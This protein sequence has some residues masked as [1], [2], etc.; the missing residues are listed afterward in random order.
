MVISQGTTLWNIDTANV[1]TGKKFVF[2]EPMVSTI[3]GVFSFKN[4]RRLCVGT[5]MVS[6]TVPLLKL[7]TEK[8]WENWKCL[9][10]FWSDLGTWQVLAI[11]SFSTPETLLSCDFLVK[12]NCIPRK[13]DSGCS[14]LITCYPPKK[15]STIVT[16]V[17]IV[18]S[19]I[20]GSRL[21]VLAIPMTRWGKNWEAALSLQDVT[22]LH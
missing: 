11:S 20:S 19:S 1:M 22:Q 21:L 8:T 16:I 10:P 7:S 4:S 13:A 5:L 15:T 2:N 3:L 6:L 12:K 18:A 17:T 14:A 9:A